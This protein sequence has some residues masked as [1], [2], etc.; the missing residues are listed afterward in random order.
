MTRSVSSKEYER[1][2]QCLIEARKRKG[3]TQAEVADK[4]ERAQ[5]FVSKYERGRRRLDVVEFLEVADV[6]EIDP[7]HVITSIA[8]LQATDEAPEQESTGPEVLTSAKS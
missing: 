6:L 8:S 7:H 4:L 2:C 1:F 3:L 5:S